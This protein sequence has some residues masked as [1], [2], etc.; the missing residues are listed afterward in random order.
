VDVQDVVPEVPEGETAIFEWDL[1]GRRYVKGT[2]PNHV[3]VAQ[4]LEMLRPESKITPDRMLVHSN[5][6]SQDHL[7]DT[8]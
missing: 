3:K 5:F 4:F 7:Y 8:E 1:D 6:S 2:M